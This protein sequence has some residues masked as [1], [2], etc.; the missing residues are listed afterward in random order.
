MTEYQELSIHRKMEVLIEE[1]VDRELPMDEALC[2]F[3]KIFIQTASQKHNGIK[4]KIADALGLH[5]NTLNNLIK[6]LKIK[7]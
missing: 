3:K 4:I 2:E 5:R 1:L 6:K 7:L